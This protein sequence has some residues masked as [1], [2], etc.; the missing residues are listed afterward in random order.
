MITSKSLCDFHETFIHGFRDF[1]ALFETLLKCS[2]DLNRTSRELIMNRFRLLNSSNYTTSE[3]KLM[4][5]NYRR[6][7]KAI[8]TLQD[9]F[10]ACG[11]SNKTVMGR[12]GSE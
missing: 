10:F 1:T 12:V 3:Q 7:E 11:V 9:A 4:Q 2:L 5:N 6:L 8:R